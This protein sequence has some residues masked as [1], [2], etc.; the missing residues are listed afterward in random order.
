MDSGAS[1]K[2]GDGVVV[3]VAV[4]AHGSHA[5]VVSDL[6]REHVDLGEAEVDDP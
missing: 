6:L 3:E 2:F 1:V 4:A 5:G